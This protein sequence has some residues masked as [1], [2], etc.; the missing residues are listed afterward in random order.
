MAAE[1]TPSSLNELITHLDEIHDR[2]S[3]K[4]NTALFIRFEAQ[5][6]EKSLLDVTPI[7]VPRLL[8]NLRLL[9]EDPAPFVSLLLKFLRPIGFTALLGLT[10]PD[11]IAGALS[12]PIPCINLLA[13][14]FLGKST[15]NSSEVA[16]VASMKGVVTQLIVTW[17]TTP[18]TEVSS[19]AT[20][21]IGALLEV[22]LARDLS[23]EVNNDETS[24]AREGGR[25]LGNGQGLM[26]RRI[27]GD[28]DIYSLFF[29]TCSLNTD[30]EADDSENL[31]NRQKTIAQTRLLTLLQKLA[32]LDFQA[33]TQSRFPELE[34][35]YG[36]EKGH[37][38]L[39][40][41]ACLKMVNTE[42]DVLMHMALIDFFAELVRTTSG[43]SPKSC[44]AS[45]PAID[46]SP[47]LEYLISSGIHN[48]IINFYLNPNDGDL[49]D[50][51]FLYKSSASYLAAYA[52][53][54]PNHIMSA[55]FGSEDTLL[56]SKIRS[57]IYA[58]LGTLP[59]LRVVDVPEWDLHLLSALPR[60]ALLPKYTT[61]G[62]Q[63]NEY[64]W[65]S[66]ILSRIPLAP[67]HPAYLRTLAVLFHG[68]SRK[69]DKASC[70][71]PSHL[72]SEPAAARALYTLY[73][74]KQPNLFVILVRLADTIALKEVALAAIH[75]LSSIITANW[76]VLPPPSPTSDGL[77]YPTEKS[78][79]AP[80]FA[81]GGPL[82]L[83]GIITILNT[84]ALAPLA[85][86]L[87]APPKTF[88]NLVGGSGDTESAAYTI[89]MARFE[90]VKVF[91]ERLKAL[92]VGM[93]EKLRNSFAERVARGPWGGQTAV[94]SSIST[95]EL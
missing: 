26:W 33:I 57:R 65:H 30:E 55:T 53:N 70:V 61:N 38:G 95:T 32:K 60:L 62:D 91:N 93:I 82:P 15:S 68:P 50:A 25:N 92:P 40:D 31:S 19:R 29:S 18:D 11:D 2:P 71:R 35:S 72:P 75:L 10:T 67:A 48:R 63:Q 43:H 9:K 28:K 5:L 14:A 66:S 39:L 17:L 6:T 76:D 37:A 87:L 46:T 83:F 56:I 84:P 34:A 22:D 51:S 86:Y 47:S 27:L 94:G 4:V 13:L 8:S 80:S 52:T 45:I 44:T 73:V 81:K 41:F 16:I 54:Y 77:Y 89:A 74:A 42:D 69:S 23:I 7:L 12:S 49:L 58:A 3:T 21:I 64:N 20:H 78:L 1:Y 85:N 88:N 59:A 90:L 36:L 24:R 79:K